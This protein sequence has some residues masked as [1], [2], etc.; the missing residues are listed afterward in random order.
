MGAGSG[1]VDCGAA[2][3]QSLLLVSVDKAELTSATTLSKARTQ[4][5]ATKGHSSLVPSMKWQVIVSEDRSNM[6]WSRT[7]MI[8]VDLSR[9]WTVFGISK[10]SFASLWA[11]K[12]QVG[13]RGR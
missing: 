3:G 13:G 9:K 8:H 1:V 2:V 7:E 10:S 12:V 5:I 11:E 6:T 4:S